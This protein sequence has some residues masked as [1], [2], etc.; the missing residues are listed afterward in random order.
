MIQVHFSDEDQ[1][2]YVENKGSISLSDLA[3]ESESLSPSRCMNRIL[4]RDYCFHS[5][6]IE[7]DQR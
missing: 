6:T 7:F 5:F 4:E 2:L 3:N 1:I